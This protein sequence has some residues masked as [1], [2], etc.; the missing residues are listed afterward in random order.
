[1]RLKDKVAIVTGG[2]RGMGEAT[3][4]LFAEEGAKVMIADLNAELGASVV[5]SIKAAGGAATFVKTDL[6]STVETKAMVETTVKTYGRLDILINNAGVDN[7]KPVTDTTDEEWDWVLDVNLKAVYVAAKY[8]IPHMIKSGGGAI[9]SVASFLGL[10]GGQD[11][12]PYCASKGGLVHLTKAMA[13]DHIGHNIRVNCVCPG[14]VNTPMLR[15]GFQSPD[16]MERFGWQTPE[17]AV[18]KGTAMVAANHPI[19]RVADPREIAQAILFLASDEASFV[20]GVALPVDGGVV[21]R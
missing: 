6:G 16:L 20:V 19:G 3:A 13:L 18:E 11:E 14:N 15:E 10:V 9:V 1:M 7:R 4:R 5:A 12:G 17:E 2:A 8:A 21:A